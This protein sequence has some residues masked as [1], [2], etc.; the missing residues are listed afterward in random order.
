LATATETPLVG[1][2]TLAALA[3]GAERRANGELAQIDTI[4][5][6]L[7]ARRAEVFA[8][9]WPLGSAGIEPPVSPPRA[10]TPQQLAAQ[11]GPRTL[12]VGHGAVEFRPVLKPSGAF[13]PEDDSELHRVSAVDHCRLASRMQAS[14]PD[15]VVPE[16]L[17]LPDAEI[18]LRAL[19]N[20]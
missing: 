4:V 3:S 6:V 12:A 16:Y 2:S 1:V 5:A 14:D 18:N 9:A 8:A 11:L 17:R 7:D 20:Q 13:I 10:L 15:Q 19:R